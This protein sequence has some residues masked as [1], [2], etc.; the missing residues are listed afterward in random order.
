M[1]FVKQ[2]N[3][4]EH[5]LTKPEFLKEAWDKLIEEYCPQE[6][7]LALSIKM[8]ENDLITLQMPRL[9]GNQKLNW[10]V[11]KTA[12]VSQNSPTGEEV[13]P[14][15]MKVQATDVGEVIG[16]CITDDKIKYV[17]RIYVYYPGQIAEQ[18]T[19]VLEI[20]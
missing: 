20:K 9:H 16:Y 11:E 2:K 12:V 4:H 19:E 13:E 15:V 14:G 6:E 5:C 7:I 3:G 1:W 8:G 18:K 10:F 17:T